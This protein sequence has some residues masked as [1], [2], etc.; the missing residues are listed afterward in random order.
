MGPLHFAVGGGHLVLTKK[1]LSENADPNA[2]TS[3]RMS[4]LH[5]LARLDPGEDVNQRNVNWATPL[6]EAARSRCIVAVELL[7]ENEGDVHRKTKKTNETP[8]EY[9]MVPNNER[10][11]KQLLAAGA[12]PI[13]CFDIAPKE[14]LGKLEHYREKNRRPDSDL[15]IEKKPPIYVST[16]EDLPED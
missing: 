5:L 4:C 11:V 13:R 2:L 8:L 7:L 10:V 3:S 14:Y 15:E 12:D 1:L 6:H 16:I 9:A